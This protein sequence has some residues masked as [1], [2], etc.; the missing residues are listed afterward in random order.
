M[1]TSEQVISNLAITDQ[2]HAYSEP[3]AQ[4]EKYESRLGLR[5]PPMIS[6]A[7]RRRPRSAPTLRE[8]KDLQ[9]ES[10]RDC[11]SSR[12]VLG[13]DRFSRDDR[14]RR[15]ESRS[16]MTRSPG[17]PRPPKPRPCPQGNASLSYGDP[18]A[19]ALLTPEACITLA[20]GCQPASAA[21]SN[22]T[23]KRPRPA[24]LP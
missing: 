10:R 13:P 8:F 23:C 9:P 11:G 12:K 7:C 2:S 14:H 18:H 16:T 24:S 15:P 17:R 6:A 19:P 20:P 4:A 21:K 5:G 3:E 22:S 1:W